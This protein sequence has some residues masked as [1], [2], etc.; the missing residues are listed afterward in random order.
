METFR[1][2][3]MIMIILLH[4]TGHG[5]ILSEVEI[6]SVNFYIVYIIHG[7]SVCAV[8]CF[9][10]MFGFF[11]CNKNIKIKKL[12]K[13]YMQ[14]I[15]YS[16]IIFIAISIFTNQI[17]VSNI[18]ITILPIIYGRWWFI[19]KYIL[20]FLISPIINSILIR[21]NK[22]NLK[23]IVLVMISILY[24]IPTIFINSSINNDNY[25]LINLIGLYVIGYFIKVNEDSFNLSK[26]KY[27]IYYLLCMF[28]PTILNITISIYSNK[29][30]KLLWQNYNFFVVLGAIML[31]L[32]FL[33]I[34][35]ESNF[36]NMIG[37]STLAVY[38]IHDD[39]MVRSILYNI[40]ETNSWAN[41]KYMISYIFI[42]SISIFIFCII[43]DK[44]RV[45][46]MRGI[47]EVFWIKLINN[48]RFDHIKKKK[49]DIFEQ[50]LKT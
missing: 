49:D 28:I 37:S 23:V 50:L 48:K 12:Y 13:L 7:L 44:I 33:N 15:F 35:I 27:M 22:N 40:F 6:E 2:V 17:L 10:I 9:I 41:E 18:I 21:F 38:I 34:K 32:F 47:E 14:I 3:L 19:T 16:I 8:D 46:I 24:I 11:Q 26:Y 45:F 29:A 5:G 25:G 43:I 1:I 39:P 31:F 42:F 4:V 20:L 36:I 30:S